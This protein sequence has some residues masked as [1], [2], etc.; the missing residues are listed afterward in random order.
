MFD[1]FESAGPEGSRVNFVC[2]EQDQDAINYAS[3]LCRKHIDRISFRKINIL[4][5]QQD[6]QFDLVWAAG[7]F[8]YFSDR[9]FCKILK[10]LIISAK[11]GGE[12][13][14]G[15]FSNTNPTRFYMKLM[16]W[17][18]HYRSSQ[19][20]YSLACFC[21]VDWRNMV[22]NREKTGVNLFLHI[23]SPKMD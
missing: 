3:Q 22:V 12:I 7:V 19:Q 16:Q 4:R 20:L 2:V 21:G 1:F 5:Y 8:D 10:K 11:P 23:Y 18:L 13:I 14:V 17:C 9:I 15:N 6:A